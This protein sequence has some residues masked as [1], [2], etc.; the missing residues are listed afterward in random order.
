MVEAIIEAEAPLRDDILAQRISRAHGWLRTGSKIRERVE[1]YLRD[2]DRTSES[3]G[4]F[5]WKKGTVV[6]L[7]D[8][9]TPSD[10]EAKRAIADIPIAELAALVVSEK[11]VLDQPDTALDVARLLGVE[12][13][14]ASS[15]MRLDEAIGRA[16]THLG[17]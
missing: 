11:D 5:I 17:S 14:A 4:T 10:T 12:R 16:R 2:V 8:Y 15:R 1:L 9:R 13:L 7:L 3:S 6:N